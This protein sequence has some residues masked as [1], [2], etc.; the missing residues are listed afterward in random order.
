MSHLPEKKKRE[1]REIEER[2]I[3]EREIGER[4]I[5]EREIGEREIGEREIG[6]RGGWLFGLV[7]HHELSL[8]I[9]FL[10]GEAKV[11]LC[12]LFVLLHPHAMLIHQP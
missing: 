4:E 12:L 10:R 9:P 11:S 7:G 6:E 2:E 5:G 3:G 8:H 1:E